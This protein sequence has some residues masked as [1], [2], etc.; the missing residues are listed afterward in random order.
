MRPA[1]LNPLFRPVT[2]LAGIGPKTGAALSRLLDPPEGEEARVVDLLFHLPVALVDRRNQPGIALAPEGAIVTL[3]VRIDRH[4]KP[5]RGNRR[6]PYRVFAHDDSGEVALTFFHAPEGWVEKLLPVGE[7]PRGIAALDVDG[8]AD[9]DLGVA[10]FDT[11]D[12]AI[13][14]NDAGAFRVAARVDS[15]L[16]GEWAI[17]TF[18]TPLRGW[19]SLKDQIGWVPLTPEMVSRIREP[20]R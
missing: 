3:K 16:R 5:P 18:A 6:M 17:A 11:D 15:G 19:T 4:Q 9:L 2:S 8:D 12:V 7:T 20:A 14:V 1:L 13:L 10:T